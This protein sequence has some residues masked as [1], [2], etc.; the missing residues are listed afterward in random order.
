MESLR[1]PKL[2]S[3]HL[4]KVF[5]VEAF[6]GGKDA[7]QN[8]TNCVR[9]YTIEQL[10]IFQKEKGF[11]LEKA[12]TFWR[13]ISIKIFERILKKKIPEQGAVLPVDLKLTL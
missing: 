13:I 6:S 4:K 5:Q 10:K 2:S 7:F 3:L 8:S 12:T 9:N 11:S 1:P